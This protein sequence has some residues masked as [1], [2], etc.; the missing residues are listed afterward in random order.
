[1]TSTTSFHEH[2]CKAL[3]AVKHSANLSGN[4]KWSKIKP[5]LLPKPFALLEAHYDNGEI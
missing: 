1:M 5:K 4:A 2:A 3:T